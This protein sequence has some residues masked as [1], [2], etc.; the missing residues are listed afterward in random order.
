MMAEAGP[1][2][3]GA[4][5]RYYAKTGTRRPREALLFALDRFEAEGREEEGAEKRTGGPGFAVDL[6]CGSGRDTTALLATRFLR[7][8]MHFL[9][10]PRSQP[11]IQTCVCP[12]T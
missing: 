12:S 1:D 8:S 6:G 2:R 9:F 11:P 3:S 7:A 4:W 5:E 10:R